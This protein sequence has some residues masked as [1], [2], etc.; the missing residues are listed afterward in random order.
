M[1]FRTGPVGMG[2]RAKF[3]REAV[4]IDDCRVEVWRFSGPLL[5]GL[6]RQ[7]CVA[8]TVWCE[9]VRQRHQRAAD[10]AGPGRA[11]LRQAAV[12]RLGRPG[13]DFHI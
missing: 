4:E 8:W 13:P 2:L 6:A 7:A 3:G 9:S 5:L 10:V 12:W 11:K 1:I